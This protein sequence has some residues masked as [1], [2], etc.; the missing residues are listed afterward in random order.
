MPDLSNITPVTRLEEFIDRISRGGGGG[1]ALPEVTSEDEGKVLT[2]VDNDGTYEWGAA[3]PEN[4]LP[5]VT[6]SNNGQVL[7]VV[8]GEWAA[9]EPASATEFLIV[10]LSYDQS[11]PEYVMNKTAGEIIEAY[12]FILVMDERMTSAPPNIEAGS[13]VPYYT[14]FHRTG[15]TNPD[16]PDGYYFAQN[17]DD[18]FGPN[19]VRFYAET[20]ADY[21]V[22]GGTL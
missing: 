13:Y 15:S 3:E 18:L 11:V 22:K 7:T 4:C 8:S 1:G 12:P 14:F 20:L 5:E 6:S 21:P 19:P 16:F 9:A 17:Y 2:V 10:G